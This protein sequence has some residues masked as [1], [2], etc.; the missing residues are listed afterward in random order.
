MPRLR[1]VFGTW[2]AHHRNRGN[3]SARQVKSW[4]GSATG[5]AVLDITLGT[6]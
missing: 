3:P 5:H 1:A 6:I 4:R 2:S